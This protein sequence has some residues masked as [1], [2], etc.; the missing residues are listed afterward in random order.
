[1]TDTIK[2]DKQ[3]EA[4][5]T[6]ER[7]ARK[8]ELDAIREIVIE[9]PDDYTFADEMLSE[10]AR[11]QDAIVAQRKSATVPLY[12]VIRTIEGWF[13]PSVD[14]LESAIKHLKLVMG[15]WRVTLAER[16]AEARRAAIAAAKADN[17]PALVTALTQERAAQPASAAVGRAV[18]RLGWK[19]ASVNVDALPREYMIPNDSLLA[20]IARDAGTGDAPPP[21]IAGVTWERAAQIGAKR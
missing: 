15:R 9:C 18:T 12:S 16:E 19:V 7:T 14:D 2:L 4:R 6:A 11:T 5:V 13:K 17:A 3:L 10:L 8:S 20:R 1:M 21:T